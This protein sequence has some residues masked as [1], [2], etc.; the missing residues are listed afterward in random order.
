MTALFPWVGIA[1][2]GG[3]PVDIEVRATDL[4]AVE[5]IFELLGD[6]LAE[7]EEGAWADKSLRWF[8]AKPG[9]R[10]ELDVFFSLTGELVKFG[11]VDTSQGRIR[12]EGTTVSQLIYAISMAG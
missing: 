5:H 7:I 6:D 8:I 2:R 4:T 12:L 11:L 1:E 10:A 3:K 9:P